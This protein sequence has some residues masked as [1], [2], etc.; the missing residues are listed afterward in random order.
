MKNNNFA[1]SNAVFGLPVLIL[2]FSREFGK[3]TW[4]SETLTRC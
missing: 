1:Y 2:I 4:K 3:T